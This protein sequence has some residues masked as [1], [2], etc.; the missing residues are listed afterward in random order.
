MFLNK[1]Q[2]SDGPMGISVALTPATTVVTVSKSMITNASFRTKKLPGKLSTSLINSHVSLHPCPPYRNSQP[3]AASLPLYSYLRA[4]A[5]NR[6]FEHAMKSAQFNY[7]AESHGTP[8]FIKTRIHFSSAFQKMRRWE[9]IVQ[10]SKIRYSKRVFR[11]LSRQGQ[12]NFFDNTLTRFQTSKLKIVV[13]KIESLE[14]TKIPKN[15]RNIVKTSDISRRSL[16]RVTYVTDFVVTIYNFL[17]RKKS[18]RSN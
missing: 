12:W 10:D 16:A 14:A 7:D 17:R 5:S 9:A 3:K 18:L 11:W 8:L 13:H 6:W 15:V 2:P 1:G 4:Q